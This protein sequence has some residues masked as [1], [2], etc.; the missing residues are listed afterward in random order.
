MRPGEHAVHGS[1]DISASGDRPTRTRH[2]RPG[3]RVWQASQRAAIAAA[4]VGLGY[5]LASVLHADAPGVVNLAFASKCGSTAAGEPGRKSILSEDPYE[6]LPGIRPHD[7][8][9]WQLT[10]PR[11]VEEMVNATIGGV[12]SR[13]RTS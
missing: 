3:G 6:D 13:A 8:E 5:G 11:Q 4:L 10:F 7:A 2:W 12:R 9:Y 1:A